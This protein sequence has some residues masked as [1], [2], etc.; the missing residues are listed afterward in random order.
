[1]LE[2]ACLK[3]KVNVCTEFYFSQHGNLQG[4][5][6]KA[7]QPPTQGGQ[8]GKIIFKNF[9]RIQYFSIQIFDNRVGV[10]NQIQ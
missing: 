10:H 5:E 9:W 1:M 7:L 4:E 6:E 2:A 8:S 3:R